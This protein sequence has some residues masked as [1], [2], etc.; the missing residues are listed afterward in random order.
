[1]SF[2]QMKV[3]NRFTIVATNGAANGH[4]PV[5]KSAATGYDVFDRSSCQ[6]VCR[7]QPFDTAF[8]FC[9]RRLALVPANPVVQ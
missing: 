1:M 8:D 4:Q 5:L 2:F 6:T 3:G 7:D 9:T